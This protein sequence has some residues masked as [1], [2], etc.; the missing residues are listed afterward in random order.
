MLPLESGCETASFQVNSGP[1]LTGNII[2]AD[3]NITVR[4]MARA[5]SKQVL[6]LLTLL[7]GGTG[8]LLSSFNCVVSKNKSPQ[9]SRII[10]VGEAEEEFL[11]NRWLKHV[12]YLLLFYLSGIKV[13]LHPSA[14]YIQI[15]TKRS[16]EGW[17]WPGVKEQATSRGKEEQH[18]GKSYESRW[19][20]EKGISVIQPICIHGEL[21]FASILY[22]SIYTILIRN[23]QAC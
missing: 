6:L 2:R 12:I 18:R 9:F 5:A 15:L 14:H 4:W 16:T 21:W 3:S 23:M 11:Q 7:A 20:L 8:N 13:T 19:M 22:L 1:R 10:R 17:L